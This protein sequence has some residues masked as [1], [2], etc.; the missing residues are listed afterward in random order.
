LAWA[1]VATGRR[2]EGDAS[3][4]LAAEL[5]PLLGVEESWTTVGD[6]EEEEDGVL[7]LTWMMGLECFWNV[8]S[9]VGGDDEQLKMSSPYLAI[10]SFRLK[11]GLS[12][13]IRND[14]GLS[15]DVDSS[16]SFSP[17]ELLSLVRLVLEEGGVR[18]RGEVDL[19]K[20]YNCCKYVAT[21]NLSGSWQSTMSSGSNSAGMFS[22]SSA[23]LNA[24]ALFS[25]TFFGLRDL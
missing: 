11:L 20:W 24:C 22:S 5:C 15:E 17:S 3:A 21:D 10:R 23:N 16:E 6:E 14:G 2:A 12:G 4:A 13:A 8:L 1:A 25:R 18:G 7:D 19:N 9:R